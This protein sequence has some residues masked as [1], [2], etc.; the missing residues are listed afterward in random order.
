MSTPAYMTPNNIVSRVQYPTGRYIFYER[1]SGATYESDTLSQVTGF[2]VYRNGFKNPRYKSQIR[3]RQNATTPLE[4]ITVYREA[5][6]ADTTNPWSECMV[7]WKHPPGTSTG[8]KVLEYSKW[9]LAPYLPSD[10]TVKNLNGNFA[11]NEAASL[12]H[13]KANKAFTDWQSGVFIGELK[14]LITLIRKTAERLV[15][16][17]FRYKR[18]AFALARNFRHSIQQVLEQLSNLW[19]EYSFAWRPLVNDIDNAIDAALEMTK[20]RT[21]VRAIA[22]DTLAHSSS[23]VNFGSAAAG[24]KYLR[25]R[26]DEVQVMYIGQVSA[27]F[28]SNSQA[29][30]KFGLHPKDWAP[31][32]YELIPWSFLIDYFVNLNGVI[33]AISNLTVNMDWTSKTVRKTSKVQYRNPLIRTYSDAVYPNSVRSVSKWSPRTSCFVKKY[34]ERSR[35]DSV[36]IPSLTFSMPDSLLKYVNIAALIGASTETRDLIRGF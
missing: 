18:D 22:S 2:G 30:K 31:T 9:A 3:D 36:P 16:L 17:I 34:V 27:T 28:G 19:L 23:W 29:L 7:E 12:F 25:T 15:N 20:E 1:L 14:E 13:Q 11:E 33:A 10:L 6:D 21:T 35:I 4:G 26:T 24:A 8:V 5:N 32:V